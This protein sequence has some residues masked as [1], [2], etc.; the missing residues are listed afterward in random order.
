MAHFLL[1]PIRPILNLA[2]R[3][4]LGFAIGYGGAK[5]I[6]PD[7]L[8]QTQLERKEEL[9]AKRLAVFFTFGCVQV[10]AVQYFL[11]VVAMQRL[12]PTAAAFSA[13]PFRQKFSDLQG[14]KNLVKQVGLDQFFY[15]PLMYFPVFYTCKE[16]LQ[17]DD[18]KESLLNP[19]RTMSNAVAK[20]VPNAVE[21][22]CALW[23]IFVPVSILQFAF[24]PM[25]LRVPTHATAGFFWC[26]ILSVMRGAEQPAK[27]EKEGEIIEKTAKPTINISLPGKITRAVVEPEHNFHMHGGAVVCEEMRSKEKQ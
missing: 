15:H 23:K 5:T 21:D 24:M 2:A 18:L 26:C 20:Y 11:F 1:R 17:G 27:A 22:L 14:M 3:Y 10:G 8:V 12:F 6:A 7:A 9:D 25:H 13:L 19:G 16:L 4:P